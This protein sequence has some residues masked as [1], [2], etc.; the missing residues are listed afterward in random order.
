LNVQNKYKKITKKIS[1]K[2]LKMA[3]GL[4]YLYLT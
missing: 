4:E 3:L 1:L 2:S